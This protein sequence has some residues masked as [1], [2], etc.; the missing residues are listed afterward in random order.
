MVASGS[1]TMTAGV[2]MVAALAVA[3][4]NDWLGVGGGTDRSA[5][6]DRRRAPGGFLPT[7]CGTDSQV[8]D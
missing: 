2:G 6:Y 7:I 3:L 1:R 5:A 8:Q 4:A